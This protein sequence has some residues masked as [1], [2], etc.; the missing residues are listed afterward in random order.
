MFLRQNYSAVPHSL[1]GRIALAACDV[2]L[3]GHY[4]NSMGI[5]LDMP[6]QY[7][8]RK[9]A[10]GPSLIMRHR[11]VRDRRH[12]GTGRFETRTDREIC[13]TSISDLGNM[14]FRSIESSS[15]RDGA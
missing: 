1:G 11:K 10:K 8:L 6:I 14:V 2:R 5:G 7:T 13:V 15:C 3:S 12:G 9:T 4:E